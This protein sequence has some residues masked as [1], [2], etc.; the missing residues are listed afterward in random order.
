MMKFFAVVKPFNKIL[1]RIE[2]KHR[3]SGVGVAGKAGK[4]NKSIRFSSKICFE[5]LYRIGRK[6][7]KTEGVQDKIFGGDNSS[8]ANF[9]ISNIAQLPVFQVNVFVGTV[10]NLHEFRKACS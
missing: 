6:Y 10:I 9:S 5:Q 1:F 4:R 3:P 2:Q 8:V 7:H